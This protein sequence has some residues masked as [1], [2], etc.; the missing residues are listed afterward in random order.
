MLSE[1]WFLTQ[2][3][4]FLSATVLS[5]DALN[6]SFTLWYLYHKI[7]A[8]VCQCRQKVAI[9][10]TSAHSNNLLKGFREIKHIFK[11]TNILL[12][13]IK[14]SHEFGLKYQNLKTV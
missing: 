12:D 10:K 13:T 7:Y 8:A 6:M 1:I 3:P 14:Y 11:P 9:N 4:L 2:K 5:N